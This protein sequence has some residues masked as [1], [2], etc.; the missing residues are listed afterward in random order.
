MNVMAVSDRMEPT[1]ITLRGPSLTILAATPAP[2]AVRADLV[3]AAVLA[4]EMAMVVLHLVEQRPNKSEQVQ[5]PIAEALALLARV[6]S[7]AFREKP[8]HH[9]ARQGQSLA[10]SGQAYL[11]PRTRVLRRHRPDP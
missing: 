8:E 6:D 5:R 9:R 7:S 11:P 1:P 10:P 3:E 4:V 2:L